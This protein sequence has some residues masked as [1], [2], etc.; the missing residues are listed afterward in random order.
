VLAL[1]RGWRSLGE[2]ALSVASE[3]WIRDWER[4]TD[5]METQWILM[6]LMSFDR[7]LMDFGTS[8]NFTCKNMVIYIL[9]I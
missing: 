7:I 9:V 1:Q 3:V 6:G 2:H 5:L 4:S 8:W